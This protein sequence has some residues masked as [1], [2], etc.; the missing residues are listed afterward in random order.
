MVPTY[1]QDEILYTRE[2]T[3]RTLR[4][5]DDFGLPRYK[6]IK[7]SYTQ[8]MIWHDG[9]QLFNELPTEAKRERNIER[10][11]EYARKFV[12]ERFS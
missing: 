3:T 1:L 8:N 12:K 6:L 10:F 5:A 9:L 7:R 11:Q 2:T 4:N